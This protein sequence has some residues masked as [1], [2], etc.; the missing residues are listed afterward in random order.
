MENDRANSA[1][2]WFAH[3]I[4]IP[5]LC[6]R[7]LCRKPV[8]YAKQTVLWQRRQRCNTCMRVRVI[9]LCVSHAIWSRNHSINQMHRIH[10]AYRYLCDS[11]ASETLDRRMFSASRPIYKHN[12]FCVRLN[13]YLSLSG[14]EKER[15]KSDKFPLVDVAYIKCTA[16]R[17]V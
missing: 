8:I 2:A 13:Y 11:G 10:I 6:A 5:T 17:R 1:R 9:Y 12:Y 14:G 15:I 16:N 4:I 7:A 3:N